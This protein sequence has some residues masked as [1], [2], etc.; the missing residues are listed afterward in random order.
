MSP[1]HKWPNFSYFSP[2]FEKKI[3]IKSLDELILF[4]E[5]FYQRH[6]LWRRG[7]TV[8]HHRSWHRG[9]CSAGGE[10]LTWRRRG[11]PRRHESWRQARVSNQSIR[12]GGR[13][14]GD[15]VGG[16]GLPRKRTR[17]DPT[18]GWSARKFYY[19]D[20]VCFTLISF[21]YFKTKIRR[22]KVNCIKCPYR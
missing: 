7:N 17:R 1:H 21:F 16:V 8:R 10:M 2:F 12:P 18:W 3:T 19:M 9:T 14:P 4:F 15:H 22:I 6:K 5:P 11:R 13:A 20:E